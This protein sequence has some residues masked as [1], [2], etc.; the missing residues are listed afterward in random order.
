MGIAK[1]EWIRKCMKKNNKNILKKNKY[2]L[3]RRFKG[4]IRQKKYTAN[5]V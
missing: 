3:K 1:R 4:K 5:H 2:V